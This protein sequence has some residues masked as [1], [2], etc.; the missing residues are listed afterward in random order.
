MP[1]CFP[2]GK[3]QLPSFCTNKAEHPTQKQSH[4]NIISYDK[5]KLSMNHIPYGHRYTMIVLPFLLLGGAV[6]NDSAATAAASSSHATLN[7]NSDGIA[8][9]EHLVEW[10]R[11]KDGTYFNVEKLEIRQSNE[12]SNCVLSV[13]EGGE[14]EGATVKNCTRAT[15]VALVAK[16][17]IKVGET[18]IKLPKDVAINAKPDTPRTGDKVDYGDMRGEISEDLGGGFVKV[19]LDAVSPDEEDVIVDAGQAQLRYPVSCDAVRKLVKEAKM[20]DE[21]DFAPWIEYLRKNPA[22]SMVPMAWSE[23]GLELLLEILGKKPTSCNLKTSYLNRRPDS[24][25]LPP[26]NIENWLEDHWH[27]RCNGA[28]DDD[29]A[30]DIY[31]AL[32][33]RMDGVNVVVPTLDLLQHRNGPAL[34]ADIGTGT[35]TSTAPAGRKQ[36]DDAIKVRAVRDI[37]AGE[38]IY[39]SYNFCADCENLKPGLYGTPEILR[40]HGVIEDYPQRWYFPEQ[41]IAFDLDYVPGS[42][43]GEASAALQVHW[44]ESHSHS[45]EGYKFLQEQLQRLE[46][47]AETELASP[48]PTIPKHELET[49]V[50][51]RHAL[52][53]ALTHAI[54]AMEGLELEEYDVETETIRIDTLCRNGDGP[55][56]CALW[57]HGRYD[58]LLPIED[59]STW[60]DRPEVSSNNEG[61]FSISLT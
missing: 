15:P 31:V 38:P 11:S 5:A 34:N 3:N 53:V 41:A 26:F 52:M 22:N 43:R 9:G 1:P 16:R 61:K 2:Y 44:I 27:R 39:A 45:A 10:F 32:A 17:D 13:R 58:R 54:K 37:R 57:Q 8:L 56:T 7:R 40:D 14:E 19:K 35:L 42:T 30:G 59:D 18:L 4:N 49:I 29:L 21:S 24:Q 28:R 25:V 12:T 48:D 51:Y 47:L 50:R 23:P 33:R 36:D 20:G 55:L 60:E 46:D 6:L